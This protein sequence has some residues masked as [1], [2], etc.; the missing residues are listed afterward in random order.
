VSESLA[1]IPAQLRQS[2]SL[3]FLKAEFSSRRFG[4]NFEEHIAHGIAHGSDD[5]FGVDSASRPLG[6]SRLPRCGR[7]LQDR[8]GAGTLTGASALASAGTSAAACAGA[9]AFASAGLS[10]AACAGATAFASAGLSAAACAGAIA[11]ASAG[12]SLLGHLLVE[13]VGSVYA[14]CDPLKYF[15]HS[16]RGD[17]DYC[18]GMFMYGDRNLRQDVAERLL[19][20]QLLEHVH[21]RFDRCVFEADYPN[22]RLLVATL[23]PIAITMLFTLTMLFPLAMFFTFFM[24]ASFPLAMLFAFVALPVNFL[25]VVGSPIGSA[26]FGLG[27]YARGQDHNY[28]QRRQFCPYPSHDVFLYICRI[29]FVES[30]SVTKSL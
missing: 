22:F 13:V 28:S 14:V 4:Q 20:G 6:S 7:A 29:A 27:P 10:A 5:G 11:F 18:V 2:F 30:V 25:S 17:Y 19:A 8:A 3:T 12:A 1:D 24:F 16:R 15:E 23:V 26:A 21:E 9:V